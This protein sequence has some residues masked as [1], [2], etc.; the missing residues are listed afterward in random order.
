MS[1][2]DLLHANADIIRKA[3]NE[4]SHLS[5][6]C[7]IIVVTNPMDVMSQIAWEVSGFNKEKVIG[8]GGVLDSSRFRTF[9]S[10]EFGIS[11][12]DIEALVLGGHGD[13][14]VP[15]PRYT[16]VKGVPITELLSQDRID[17]LIHR[18][19]NGGAE[20]V[21]LLKTGSAYY[22]PAAS[23]V[24][25]VQSILFDEKRMLPCAVLLDG[26]Y[27]VKGLFV[28]VPVILAADGVEKIIELNLTE[29]ERA[30]FDKSVSAVKVLLEIAQK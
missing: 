21:S 28:G 10:R 18:T 24:Q 9:V 1:R 27:G 14:M 3:T 30:E 13:Q 22:A 23:T 7:V 26:E 2:D 29:E 12:N 15:L 11:P 25:M 16:T 19:R 17:A 4:T 6:E 8:M 20:I 5:P